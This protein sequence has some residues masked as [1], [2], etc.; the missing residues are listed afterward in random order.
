[1]GLVSGR[2]RPRSFGR[3]RHA[4]GELL[5]GI[6]I[7]LRR[8]AGVMSSQWWSPFIGGVVAVR[9]GEVAVWGGVAC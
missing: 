2:Y 9:G 6:R 3:G 8:V 5:H 7:S 4:G 1:M